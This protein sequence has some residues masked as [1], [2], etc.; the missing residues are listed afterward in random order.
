MKRE[1]GFSVSLQLET[2]LR[3]I[4]PFLGFRS[5]YKGGACGLTKENANKT[6]LT[7]GQE[8]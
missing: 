6:V 8:S 1:Y 7:E 4:V 2:Y 3:C 5:E